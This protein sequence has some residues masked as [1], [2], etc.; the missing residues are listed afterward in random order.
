MSKKKR[1]LRPPCHGSEWAEG[2]DGITYCS[3]WCA[4]AYGDQAASQY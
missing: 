3:E 2:K 1:E 4:D